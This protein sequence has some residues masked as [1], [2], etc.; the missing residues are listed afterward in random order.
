MKRCFCVTLAAAFAVASCTAGE[1]PVVWLNNVAG[2]SIRGAR[3]AAAKAFLRVSGSA[4][5]EIVVTGNDLTRAGQAV[6]IQEAGRD[7]VVETG[8]ALAPGTRKR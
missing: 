6:E 8:N 5:R 4:S 3:A 1:A 2:A 7:S